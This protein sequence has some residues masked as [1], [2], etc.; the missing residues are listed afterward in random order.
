[1][2]GACQCKYWAWGLA[3][4]PRRSPANL[5]VVL[6]YSTFSC[7]VELLWTSGTCLSLFSLFDS[8]SVQPRSKKPRV[9]RSRRI[10]DLIL[11]KLLESQMARI[12][13]LGDWICSIL[14]LFTFFIILILTKNH[15]YFSL[16]LPASTLPQILLR[17]MNS[18][19]SSSQRILF[20]PNLRDRD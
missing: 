8:I 7:S 19:F 5:A 15:A 10:L 20:P 13:S 11:C 6:P 2:R 3:L 17:S 9:I 1:M 4:Y 14:T 12:R 18:S 16:S